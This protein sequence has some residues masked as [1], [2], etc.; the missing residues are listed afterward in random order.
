[1]PPN[2]TVHNTISYIENTLHRIKGSE[3]ECINLS[4]QERLLRDETKIFF[5]NFFLVE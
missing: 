2:S 4:S 1:M 5:L 3:Q